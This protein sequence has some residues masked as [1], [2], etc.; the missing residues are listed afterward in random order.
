[1]KTIKS[2]SAWLRKEEKRLELRMLESIGVQEKTSLSGS[3]MTVK[4]VREYMEGK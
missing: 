2:V 1:M 4:K 3:L